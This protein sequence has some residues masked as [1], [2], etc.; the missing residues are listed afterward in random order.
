MKIKY[1]T[2]ITRMNVENGKTIKPSLKL[3]NIL[4]T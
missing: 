2:T 3:N 4:Y 1:C